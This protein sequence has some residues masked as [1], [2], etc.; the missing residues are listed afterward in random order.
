VHG[1]S[2][3]NREREQKMR[4]WTVNQLE[5]KNDIFQRGFFR[6][7]WCLIPVI[8]TGG[9]AAILSYRQIENIWWLVLSLFFIAVVVTILGILIDFMR[10]NKK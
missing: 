1:E 5:S 4:I 3:N 8:L 9:L 7:F 2:L 6:F 10:L